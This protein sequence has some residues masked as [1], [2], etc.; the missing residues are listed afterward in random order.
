METSQKRELQGKTALVTGAGG[1]LGTAITRNLIADGV[2]VWAADLHGP[3]LKALQDNLDADPPGGTGSLRPLEL[4]VRDPRDAAAAVARV[5]D[6]DGQLDLLVNNAAVDVTLPVTELRA[7]D[8]ELVIGTDLLGPI[9]LCLEAF[10]RMAARGSG[11]I[12]NVLSTAALDTWTEAGLYSA[13]KHGLRAF[14]H[15]LFREARRDCPGV[16][17]TGIV[18]GG[19]RTPFITARFPEADVSMLQEPSVV[20]DALRFVL[21]QPIHSLVPELVVIP[22]R[23][24]TWP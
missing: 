10:P 8:A 1:G 3:A 18:A 5:H 12:V 21:T 20:A 17:I 2:R 6:E 19:M 9:F 7:E 22:H 11:Y 24:P 23:E 15:T 14:T 4:D 16:G 13:A